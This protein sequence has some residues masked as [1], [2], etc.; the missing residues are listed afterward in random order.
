MAGTTRLEL[1]T[2]AVTGQRSNQLNYVPAVCKPDGGRSRIRI[3]ELPD[4]NP[5]EPTV[6]HCNR[7]GK[8]LSILQFCE[9]RKSPATAVGNLTV[10]SAMAERPQSAAA[11]RAT[12]SLWR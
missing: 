7:V 11:V 10:R 1:A 12:T 2:S 4:A 3:R 9:M 5:F 8:R 6:S